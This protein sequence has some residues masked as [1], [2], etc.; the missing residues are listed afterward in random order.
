MRRCAVLDRVEGLPQEEPED[1]F[2]W[3]TGAPAG[4]ARRGDLR[5]AM[6]QIFCHGEKLITM[7]TWCVNRHAPEFL[8]DGRIA[9]SDAQR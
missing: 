2:I 6:V 8:L 5:I 9:S 7:L 1:R 3:N 4:C